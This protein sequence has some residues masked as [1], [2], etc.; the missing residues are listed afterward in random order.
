M[1]YK[2]KLRIVASQRVHSVHYLVVTGCTYRGVNHACTACHYK[3][4][5]PG[6]Q[7]V[8]CT[9]FAWIQSLEMAVL[10]KGARLLA[11]VIHRCE[12]R[13]KRA[14]VGSECVIHA[15]RGR[16]TGTAHTSTIVK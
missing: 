12:Q 9:V 7:H 16:A 14:V 5:I 15:L 8:Q 6:C 2:C 13:L 3:S 1:P 11:P 10:A 4:K